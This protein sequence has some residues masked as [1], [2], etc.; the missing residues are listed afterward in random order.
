M[1]CSI[2][3]VKSF[4][5]EAPEFPVICFSPEKDWKQVDVSSF[6]EGTS[7]GIEITTN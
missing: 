6:S 2:A 4:I 1:F 5:V 7:P 3:A